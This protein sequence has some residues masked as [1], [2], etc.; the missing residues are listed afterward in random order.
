[1]PFVRYILVCIVLLLPGVWDTANG[2]IPVCEIQSDLL[3]SQE[4]FL[5]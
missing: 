5:I 1:M 3:N 2:Y 4:V